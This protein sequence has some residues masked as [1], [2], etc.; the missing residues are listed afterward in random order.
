MISESIIR[1]SLIGKCSH[2]GK[3][4]LGVSITF[5]APMCSEECDNKEFRAYLIACGKPP[6]SE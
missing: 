1:G 5:E 6:G 4:T 3:E 2:C